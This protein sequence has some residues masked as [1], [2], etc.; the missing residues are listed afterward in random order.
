V[1]PLAALLSPASLLIHTAGPFQSVRFP[2]PLLACVEAGVDYLDVCD[3]TALIREI[4]KG[5]LSERARKKGVSAIVS[6]GI[7]PGCSALLARRAMALLPPAAAPASPA[8]SVLYDFYTAGT[9]N[10]G[11]TI[12]SATFLLLAT[13]V[14]EWRA[15]SL[16]E[17]DAWTEEREAGF[18]PEVPGRKLLRNLD[19]PDTYTLGLCTGTPNVSSSFATAPEV[20]NQLFSLSKR[21]IP[22]SLLLNRAAMQGLA[23]FSNPIIRLVDKLVGAT[24][25]IQVTAT[26]PTGERARARHVHRDLEEAVGQ[27]TASFALEL[28]EGKVEPGVFVPA[29]LSRENADAILDR[30]CEVGEG[31]VLDY[32]V[33]LL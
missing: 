28:L 33:R 10:A 9:G 2:L 14:L 29:G 8:S 6:A 30:V 24:N 18:G 3:E 11:P 26:A 15:G 20:W 31:G 5:D 13:P 25:A 12:V 16:A 21:L 32:E 17:G 4:L 27:A 7:W 23:V 1:A 19:C 22:K